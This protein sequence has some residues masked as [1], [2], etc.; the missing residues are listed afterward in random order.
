[1]LHGWQRA[2]LTNSG[3]GE[4]LSVLYS[5]PASNIEVDAQVFVAARRLVAL[6]DELLVFCQGISLRHAIEVQGYIA[7]VEAAWADVVRLRASRGLRVQ[8]VDDG[9]D[10]YDRIVKHGVK[11]ISLHHQTSLRSHAS[12]D[13]FTRVLLR[14]WSGVLRGRAV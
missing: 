10:G 11:G 8:R 14:A 3:T 5:D 9:D 12:V 6:P 1:M 2:E 13:R 4:I 7:M